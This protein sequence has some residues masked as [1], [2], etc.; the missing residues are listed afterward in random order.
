MAAKRFKGKA[1]S[2]GRWVRLLDAANIYGLSPT[3]LLKQIK[4]GK[5]RG[6]QVG[7]HWFVFVDADEAGRSQQNLTAEP[8]QEAAS[9]HDA[10]AA[11]SEKLLSELSG[12]RA[13]V[14]ALAAGARK[15]HESDPETTARS[16][17]TLVRTLTDESETI[18]SE[19][20]FLRGELQEVRRQHAEEMRRKDVLLQK[21]QD[22]LL[23]LLSERSAPVT[24]DAPMAALTHDIEAMQNQ[25]KKV[26]R[27]LGEM[28]NL[29]A[30]IYRKVQTG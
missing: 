27:V 10:D 14:E 20:D 28:T 5:V 9:T 25:Q 30:F 26:M 6:S 21:S 16:L 15:P 4:Q 29:M 13:Q 23:K 1:D 3:K 24:Q 17:N 11:S 22:M 18:R 19:V 12:L 7:D 8:P 2:Q